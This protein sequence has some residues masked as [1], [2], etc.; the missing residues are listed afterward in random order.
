MIAT[1]ACR[2]PALLALLSIALLVLA[3]GPHREEDLELSGATAAKVDPELRRAASHILAEGHADS[4]LPVLV[5]IKGGDEDR[6]E[7]ERAGMRIE[8][9]VGDVATGS[10]AARS[11]ADVAA[12]ESVVQIEPSRKLEIKQ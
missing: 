11:L 3:C 12:L 5:R 7:L 4:T 6:G 2:F 9:L 8:S 1:S 10:L